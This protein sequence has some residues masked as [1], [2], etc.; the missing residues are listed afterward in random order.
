MTS[1]ENIKYTSYYMMPIL[2]YFESISIFAFD[3]RETCMLSRD[4]SQLITAFAETSPYL[5]LFLLFLSFIMTSQQEKAN[6]MNALLMPG[7]IPQYIIRSNNKQRI[8]YTNSH[9]QVTISEPL[10]MQKL[11]HKNLHLKGNVS[12]AKRCMNY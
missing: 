2:S 7:K 12:H 5:S 11:Y 4:I 10:K 1:C 6:F 3:Y 8:L 9:L